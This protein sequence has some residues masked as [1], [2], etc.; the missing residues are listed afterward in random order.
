MA[1]RDDR[2]PNNTE[3]SALQK[4][5]GAGPMPW[6]KL[7]PA[8]KRTLSGMLQKGWITMEGQN[9]GVTP[10]GESAFRAKIPIE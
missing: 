6:F 2:I 4:L 8:G 7:H 1:L 3:R 9:Y 5:I 10:A